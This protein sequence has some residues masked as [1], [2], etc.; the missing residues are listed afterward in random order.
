MGYNPST[1]YAGRGIATYDA[2]M[3]IDGVT[4][5]NIGRI[6]IYVG[7]G[8]TNAVISNNMYTGKGVGNWLD[9]GIEVERGGIATI[10]GNNVSNNKGV[11]N[12]GSTSA[13]I[14]ATTYFNPG[15]TATIIGNDIKD[16]TVG[17]AV[18]YDAADTT[19]V[20]AHYNNFTGNG[21]TASTGSVA[22]IWDKR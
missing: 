6:G 9:Y 19:T 1:D 2:N 10:T 13:G 4:L 7:S 15:T 3:V 21:I 11:A 18:G 22:E 14:L 20:I 8:V 17:I 12:D 16:N 5:S